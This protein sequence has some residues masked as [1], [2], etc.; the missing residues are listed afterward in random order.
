MPSSTR[1]R[2]VAEL[3][4]IHRLE[5]YTQ[6]HPQEVLLVRAAIAGEP[7]EILVFRG[8]SSSLTGPTAFDPDVP[9]LPPTAEITAIDR[10]QAPYNP[11]SAPVLW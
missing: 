10:L 1:S 4:P 2:T 6:D 9:V 8:F 7:A 3:L 5:T 11:R